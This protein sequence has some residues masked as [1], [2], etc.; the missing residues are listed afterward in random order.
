VIPRERDQPT[1]ALSQSH[2]LEELGGE[3]VCATLQDALMRAR[4]SLGEGP[5]APADNPPPGGRV[6]PAGG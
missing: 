5:A 4:T 1:S 6:G 3:N 2:L